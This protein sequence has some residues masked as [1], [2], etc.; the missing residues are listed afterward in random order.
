M[1][2]LTERALH[3]HTHSEHYTHTHCNLHCLLFY[4]TVVLVLIYKALCG[5]GSSCFRDC[6]FFH[7]TQQELLLLLRCSSLWSICLIK[8]MLD[9]YM[10]SGGHSD[11]KLVTTSFQ[12]SSDRLVFRTSVLRGWLQSPESKMSQQHLE[13]RSLCLCPRPMLRPTTDFINWGRVPKIL[14]DDH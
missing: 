11:L 1:V 3:T 12:Q 2:L 8:T 14:A 4:F 7:V 13:S 6:L 9:H 5:L 10:P